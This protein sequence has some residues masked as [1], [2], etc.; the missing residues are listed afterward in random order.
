MDP[1]HEALHDLESWSPDQAEVYSPL[2]DQMREA[3]RRFMFELR[4]LRDDQSAMP[5]ELEPA[6]YIYEAERA[7]LGDSWM[8][9]AKYLAWCTDTFRAWTDTGERPT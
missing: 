3:R 6:E 4:R 7:N 9:L 1:I 2:Q 8:Q 5:A